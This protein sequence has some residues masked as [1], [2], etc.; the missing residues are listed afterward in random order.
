MVGGVCQGF[1]GGCGGT[2]ARVRGVYG[3]C[4][5]PSARIVPET[6]G[7]LGRPDRLLADFRGG[8]GWCRGVGVEC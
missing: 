1:F 7:D 2:G 8:I 4:N 5:V 6:E 3:V